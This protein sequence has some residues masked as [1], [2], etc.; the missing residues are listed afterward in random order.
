MIQEIENIVCIGEKVPPDSLH[1]PDRE[2]SVK[3]TRQI[4]MYLS[5]TETRLTHALIGGYFGQDHATCSNSCKRIKNLIDSDPLFRA[6]VKVYEDQVKDKVKQETK[7]ESL[8]ADLTSL[9]IGIEI[10]EARILLMKESFEN[11][12]SEIKQLK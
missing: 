12:K 4:I 1:V 7:I 10:V 3:E 5:K 11:L 8:A 6:K 9:L 2:T